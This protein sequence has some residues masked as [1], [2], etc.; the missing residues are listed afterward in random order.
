MEFFSSLYLLIDIDTLTSKNYLWRLIYG[1][2]G[3]I[4][5]DE[6]VDFGPFSLAFTQESMEFISIS[7]LWIFTC[8]FQRI[9]LGDE[10]M[11][12]K[13]SSLEMV[14]WIPTHYWRWIC[15]SQ[16][17]ISGFDSRDDE[18]FF[19]EIIS[20]DGYVYFKELSMEMV[21]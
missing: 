15:A 3:T 6:Y 21:S 9:I 1:F 17:I 20:R 2:Q 19:Q 8:V 7:Y 16:V 4:S 5:T 12:F 14:I 10:Y 13:K 18:G 11:D